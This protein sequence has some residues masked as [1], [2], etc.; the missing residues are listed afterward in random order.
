MTDSVSNNYNNQYQYK[1]SELQKYD[2]DSDGNLSIFEIE[3]IQDDNDI[4]L[5]AEDLGYMQVAIEEP[6][7]EEQIQSL[8]SKLSS[9]KDEQGAIS[10]AWNAIK[11]FTGLGSSTDK[12]EQAISDF[13]NGKITY[14]E[15]DSIISEFSTKQQNSVNLAANIA[16]GIVAVA[17][18]GTAV[19]T[20]GLSLVAGAAIGAGVGAATKAGLKFAD[21]ATN[22]VEGDALD[23][24]QITKDALSGAVDGAVS[25]ATLGI[26]SG[27][28][29]AKNVAT[30]TLKQTVIQGAKIGAIDGAVSGAVTGAAD[31]TIE[32]ALEEDV[33]FNTADLIKTTLVNTAG[34][35]ITGGIMGSASAGIQ[36]TKLKPSVEALSSQASKLNKEYSLH[37]DEAKAQVESVFNG[38]N[39]VQ[40]ISG[41]AKSE[42]SI[43]SKLISKFDKGKL[44]STADDACFNAIG[45][46]YGTRLQ[47]KNL[48][49]EETKN[50]I[51]DCLYGYDI[52]YEQFIK[53]MDGGDTSTL[54]EAGI[55]TIKEI[56]STVID[57]LKEQQTQEAVDS[58]CE[59]IISGKFTITELNN[60]G[61]D[62][63]S[64]FTQTQLEQ[65]SAAYQQANPGQKLDIVT[66]LDTYNVGKTASVDVDDSGVT[67]VITDKSTI[68]NKGATKD[69]GYTSSQM[70]TKHNF[71]DGS[72]G[73]GELQIRGTEVNQ[74]ADVEHIPYDIRQGK[75]T[76]SDTKYKEIYDVI[77]DMSDD[78]Y[79]AYNSYLKDVYNYLRLK[80]L[81]IETTEPML[82]SVLKGSGLSEEAINLL[83][84]EGLTKIATKSS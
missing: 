47:L 74:F 15:A 60:Y 14:E 27:A 41:R 2:T 19:A 22:K 59:N 80:E 26:G 12:C 28:V 57:L 72:V 31:Y 6:S 43:L 8:E 34:G 16:T 56:K 4:E 25:V 24:K 76:A 37:I 17:A 64:Y 36:Y 39:S 62:I 46:G 21:R 11:C 82:E 52:S 20:G 69:S 84:R 9:V 40:T 67:T 66:Q 71:E 73:L 38:D 68:T 3:N 29:T 32:A 81:G 1:N 65:I 5:L 48:S 70:N 54:S 7:T 49:T 13:K 63:S 45:D 10:S 55:A 23:A 61:N 58:L 53:Y 35:A 18:V 42:D 75:I 51:E 30:Q 33:E 50:I 44:A 77:K 79:T 78:T 83:S